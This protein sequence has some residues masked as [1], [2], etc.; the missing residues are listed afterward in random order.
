MTQFQVTFLRKL[1]F[2]SITFLY[3]VG[4]GCSYHSVDPKR[5]L[6]MS[7][8]SIS[9]DNLFV[10]KA[11]NEDVNHLHVAISSMPRLQCGHK[12]KIH[13]AFVT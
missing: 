9:R 1:L 2:P 6:K 5:R 12:N 11:R 4:S 3:S 8:C 10:V 13:K 7:E